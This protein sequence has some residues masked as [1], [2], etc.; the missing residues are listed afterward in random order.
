MD[1]IRQEYDMDENHDG[2]C[3][4]D[5]MYDTVRVHDIHEVTE[6]MCSN[7]GKLWLF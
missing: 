6:G 5:D 7:T 4:D 2:I 1:E 3:T